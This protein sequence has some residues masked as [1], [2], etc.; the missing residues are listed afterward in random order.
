MSESQ[1][2]NKDE[3]YHHLISYSIY[4]NGMTLE[5]LIVTLFEK[6]VFAHVR[7]LRWDHPRLGCALKPMTCFLIEKKMR[8][9][10]QRRRPH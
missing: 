5:P 8:E 2:W 9:N 6:R 4:E 7:I 10:T 1:T 3:S